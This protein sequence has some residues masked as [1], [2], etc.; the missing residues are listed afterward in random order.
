M[1]S[2]STAAA[3]VVNTPQNSN[4]P[5]P[6]PQQQQQYHRSLSKPVDEGT[7]NSS[8][9]KESLIYPPVPETLPFEN[10][11][12]IDST[13]RNNNNN[14]SYTGAI[15]SLDNDEDGHDGD[16]D[17]AD[18]DDHRSRPSRPLNLIGDSFSRQILSSTFVDTSVRSSP[19]HST[20]LMMMKGNGGGIDDKKKPI[21]SSSSSS[22][23]LIDEHKKVKT[24]RY[25][26]LPSRLIAKSTEQLNH[27]FAS[28][29]L[30][31]R[32]PLTSILKQSS[33]INPSASKTLCMPITSI[34]ISSS[35]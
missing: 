23:L 11:R 4:R 12:N 22:S 25:N 29:S 17:E 30:V 33:A 7:G 14:N 20:I 16:V 1:N 5:P 13:I 26:F 31:N 35:S 18:D 24:R 10:Y 19:N 15:R 21:N 27:S 8:D 2:Q 32:S 28:D 3:A 6:S 34:S 9:R